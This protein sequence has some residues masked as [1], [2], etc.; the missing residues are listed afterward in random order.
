ML[1]PKEFFA[2][3]ERWH[4]LTSQPPPLVEA[5]SGLAGDAKRSPEH[6]VAHAAW[7]RTDGTARGRLRQGTSRAHG[8]P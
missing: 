5:H 1:D 4:E 3:I 6:Q 2:R 8:E 7:W